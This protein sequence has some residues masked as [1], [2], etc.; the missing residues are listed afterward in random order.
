MSNEI[1]IVQDPE[2]GPVTEGCDEC[3][4][5][6]EL[7]RELTL[8]QQREESVHPN[9]FIAVFAGRQVHEGKTGHTT[10]GLRFIIE[11]RKKA[12]DFAAE[13]GPLWRFW[14]EFS[15]RYLTLSATPPDEGNLPPTPS[16]AKATGSG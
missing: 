9:E 4:H 13:G 12:K 1:R 10:F 15:E 7:A 8:R 11:A 5:F 3:L 14:V 6:R 2:L 16:P